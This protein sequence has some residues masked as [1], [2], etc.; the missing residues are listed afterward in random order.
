MMMCQTLSRLHK[1][2]VLRNDHTKDALGVATLVTN[3]QIELFR[4]IVKIASEIREIVKIANEK[5][6]FLF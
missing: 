5:C 4:E 1:T 3:T 6:K 2:L